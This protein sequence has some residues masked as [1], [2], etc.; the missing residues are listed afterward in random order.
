MRK[1][2][3]PTIE[4]AVTGITATLKNDSFVLSA[5]IPPMY[6]ADMAMHNS[7]VLLMLPFAMINS[8]YSR[9]VSEPEIKIML[10]AM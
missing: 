6:R 4:K 7:A 8:E 5:M 3:I 9:K 10:R 1:N 2:T